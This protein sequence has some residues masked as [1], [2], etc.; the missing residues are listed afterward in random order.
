MGII[1]NVALLRLSFNAEKES[2]GLRV[3]VVITILALLQMLIVLIFD[4]IKIFVY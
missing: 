4:S 1:A 2:R 3:F